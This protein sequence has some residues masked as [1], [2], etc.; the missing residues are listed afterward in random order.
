MIRTN[1][2]VAVAAVNRVVVF[3][4]TAKMYGYST[5]TT[6]KV[7]FDGNNHVGD[8]VVLV[9][10]PISIDDLKAIIANHLTTE[11]DDI[12]RVSVY[13]SKTNKLGCPELY[14]GRFIQYL[15]GI[16]IKHDV[17]DKCSLSER[18]VVEYP[19]HNEEG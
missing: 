1:E 5:Q 4:T 14:L 9:S 12:I 2:P 3:P 8:D 17:G 7:H 18:I 19:T 13:R 6:Y 10:A 15:E 11:F 16:A